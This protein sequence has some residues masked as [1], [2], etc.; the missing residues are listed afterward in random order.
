[1]RKSLLSAFEQFLSVLLRMARAFM[2]GK[3][4]RVEFLVVGVQKGGTTALDYYLRQHPEICMASRKEV[5]FFD[6]E[7]LQKFPKSIRK[8]YYHSFFAGCG[9]DKLWG[10]V[11]PIYAWWPKCIERMREYNPFFKIIMVLR[12]PVHRAYSHWNMERQR[13]LENEPFSV[14]IRRN[15]AKQSICRVNSYVSRG[16]YSEQVRRLKSYFQDKQLLF[17]KQEDLLN[18]LHSTMSRVT[19]FLEVS[20]MDSLEVKKIHARKYNSPISFYDEKYLRE[21]YYEDITKLEKELGWDLSQWKK[22]SQ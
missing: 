14:C 12:D 4:K 9:D 15:G 10:E 5:H 2:I 7:L 11:T 1:M 16:F 3:S 19:V 13:G 20:P 22:V 18:S 6:N 8:L 17:I 21:L